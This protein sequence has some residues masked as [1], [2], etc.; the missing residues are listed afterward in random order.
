MDPVASPGPLAPPLHG[1]A[2]QSRP[3]DLP[4]DDSRLRVAAKALEAGFLAEMLKSAGLGASRGDFGGGAG[5]DHFASYLVQE[6]ARGMVE[7][8]GIGLAEALFEAMKERADD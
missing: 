5:E 8:G 2:G 1:P 3:A 4:S 6:Q 7:A